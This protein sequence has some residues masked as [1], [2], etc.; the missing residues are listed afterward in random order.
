M[1]SFTSDFKPG[2]MVGSV[3]RIIW[4]SEHFFNI[5]TV[6]TWLR[7]ED[8]IPD[9]WK[10]RKD[11]KTTKL[12]DDKRGPNM[13]PG[14]RALIVASVPRRRTW[15]MLLLESGSYCWVYSKDGLEILSPA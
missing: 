2:A 1:T 6:V 4:D 3:E 8:C 5:N 13:F 11:I 12:L 15:I 14:Q 7:P 10:R 9:L